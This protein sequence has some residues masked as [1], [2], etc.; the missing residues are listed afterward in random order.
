MWIFCSCCR[1]KWKIWIVFEI[2]KI[3]GNFRGLVSVGKKLGEKLNVCK[4]RKG[5]RIVLE[6]ELVSIFEWEFLVVD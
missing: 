2:E 5:G 4:F 3:I 1:N 6:K